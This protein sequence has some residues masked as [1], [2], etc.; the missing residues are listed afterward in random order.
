MLST[1]PRDPFSTTCE[2]AIPEPYS[3]QP[4]P[5]IPSRL[6]ARSNPRA[7]VFRSHHK[8]PV[9]VVSI[10]IQLRVSF[11]V[12]PA[13][14]RNV[15][16]CRGAPTYPPRSLNSG[17]IHFTGACPASAKRYTATLPTTQQRGPRRTHP[18][19][20]GVL[21]IAPR[22]PDRCVHGEARHQHYR[23]APVRPCRDAELD[24]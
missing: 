9:L 3:H 19:R 21:A 20:K 6:P 24:V 22:P 11:T 12:G 18:M 17:R 5:E 23:K 2:K 14:D 10:G 7:I 15:L 1:S 16:P 4:R 13:I 8:Y